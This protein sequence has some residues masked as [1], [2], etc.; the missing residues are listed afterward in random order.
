MDI[1]SQ[2][3]LE[4]QCALGRLCSRTGSHYLQNKLHKFQ[5]TIILPSFIL[6]MEVVNFFPFFLW[7]RSYCL[8][9]LVRYF[10]TGR[11]KCFLGQRVQVG[12]GEEDSIGLW[13]LSFTYIQE[14]LE[15]FNSLYAL[16]SCLL[17]DTEQAEQ[18]ADKKQPLFLSQEQ[19]K[20]ILNYF[21]FCSTV[22]IME[23]F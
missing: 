2:F 18:Q 7:R 9:E 13:Y 6:F 12:W 23:N 17:T 14:I 10:R 1:K 19:R 11:P 20:I 5:N 15:V 16:M 3:A 21:F 8:L 22:L 4:H